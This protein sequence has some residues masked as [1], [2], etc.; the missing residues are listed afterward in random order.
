ML[1]NDG[2]L[3]LAN[4]FMNC[5]RREFFSLRTGALCAGYR[6]G[7]R[8]TEADRGTRSHSHDVTV[9]GTSRLREA[10]RTGTIVQE[11]CLSR[12]PLGPLVEQ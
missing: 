7:P 1:V 8:V 11:D 3:M 5:E 10:S 9:G 12:L 2:L 6:I 4:E